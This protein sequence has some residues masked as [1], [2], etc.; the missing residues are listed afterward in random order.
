MRISTQQ[1]FS[2]GITGLQDQQAKV[3]D[4]QQRLLTGKKL[5]APSDDPIGASRAMD[6]QREIDVTTQY[7]KNSDQAT[8]QLS[9]EESTL[10]SMNNLLV[11][12]RELAVQGGNDVVGASQRANIASDIR[13]QLDDLVSLANKKGP[14]GE[15]LFGGY[16]SDTAPVTT[17]GAGNF[18]YNGDS[19]QRKVK[20]GEFSTVAI[21]DPGSSVFMNVK[22]AAGGTQD[23]FTTLYNLASDL[24][25]NTF[26]GDSLDNVDNAIANV[27]Q[28]RSGVGN[29]LNAIDNQ[30]QAND[31]F[32]LQLQTS[33]SDVQDLDYA[34]AISRLNQQMLGLQAA[35]QTFGKLQSLSLFNYM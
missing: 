1:I 8:S 31:G 33:L 27:N 9:L 22:A 28:V 15:Y 19:N 5:L 24:E 30:K 6:L 14:N 26:N 11:R 10:A 16:Q 20:T 7:Q 34:E 2:Q 29:R 25:N 12:V 23:V 4:T 17:D 3:N 13:Q 32:V 18:T 21:G 35:Q